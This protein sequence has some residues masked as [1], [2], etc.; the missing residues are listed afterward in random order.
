MHTKQNPSLDM[1]NKELDAF[2]CF[3]YLCGCMN[4]RSFTIDLVVGKV[5]LPGIPSDDGSRPLQQDR[6]IYQI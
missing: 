4:A 1:N 3:L 2:V 6:E 5:R